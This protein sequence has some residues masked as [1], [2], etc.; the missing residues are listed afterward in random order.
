MNNSIDVSTIYI[1]SLFSGVE[2]LL[3]PDTVELRL[4]HSA[5]QV[6]NDLHA[7][8]HTH[9][10]NATHSLVV[11]EKA[12]CPRSDTSHTHFKLRSSP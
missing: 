11:I 10:R 2:S 9:T 8:T 4:K 12:L 3:V 7:L 1:F 6:I 5:A